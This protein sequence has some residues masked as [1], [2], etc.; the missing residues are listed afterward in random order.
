MR[1]AGHVPGG[2]RVLREHAAGRRRARRHAPTQLLLA[3]SRQAGRLIRCDPS[4]YLF[5][6]DF[7]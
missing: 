5:L 2:L 1:R 6:N 4:S 7:L 3:S